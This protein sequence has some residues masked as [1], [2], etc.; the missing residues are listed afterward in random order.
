MA[1]EKL[2][3]LVA[4]IRAMLPADL[5]TRV[6]HP[7]E[8][9]RALDM[10]APPPLGLDV[11]ETDVMRELS[12]DDPRYD[13][14]D[15]VFMEAEWI[16]PRVHD[17]ATRMVWL[18]GGGYVAGSPRGYRA[19]VAR[20]A[21]AAGAAT[22]VPAYR[23]APEHRFPAALDDARCALTHAAL[24]DPCG[25]RSAARIVLGGDSAGG[26]LA[27]A[28]C[29]S[30][31]DA[32][33]PLPD[34]LVLVSPWAD[35]EGRGASMVTRADSLLPPSLLFDWARH[36][37]GPDG[38]PRSPLASPV[39]ADLRSLPPMLIQ[40]GDQ[41]ILLDDST[42]LADRARAAGVRVELRVFAEM[43]HCFQA[44]AGVLPEARAAIEEIGEFVRG[45]DQK[46]PASIE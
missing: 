38:D 8:I 39:H 5:A 16:V 28:T 37:L 24:H 41:E 29:V 40:V 22:F 18:H 26:G 21:K 9:R 20:L 35:L 32:G 43:F 6:P 31:R 27:V 23:L 15:A 33:A 34:A 7:H 46:K 3:R 4:Q 12:E 42:R 45:A 30:A 14:E 2:D 25:A 1:H 13:D 10:V 19:F 44:F 11:R 36:Y 17:P